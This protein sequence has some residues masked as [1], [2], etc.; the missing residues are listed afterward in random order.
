MNDKN[1]KSAFISIV[2]MANVGKS[3]LLN[4]L[5]G[6]KISIISNKPQ[7]TRNKITGILTKGESQLVFLDSPGYHKRKNKLSDYM[8]KQISSVIL[9]VD[10]CVLVVE[11]TN[12]HISEL[13]KKLINQINKLNVDVILVINKIDLLP[14]KEMIIKV[15]EMYSTEINVKSVVP[16]SVKM[17]DGIN[18][19]L[20]ELYKFAKP[21]P[22]FFSDDMITDQMEREMVSEI[23]R[24]K[25]LLNFGAEIPYGVVVAI[26]KMKERKGANIF[27]IESV[28]YCERNSHKG[29]IIGKDGQALK[30]AASQARIDIE[31]MLESKVNLKCWVK[32]KNNWRN[33]EKIMRNFGYDLR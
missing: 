29:I 2:G 4:K 16:I 23:I 15:I 6:Q 17:N 10:V 11:A 22:H 19:L 13:E 20:D 1:S 33:N 12:K 18:I 5:V 26:E 9:D 8:I 24:E 31:E 32:V 21:S 30:K 3:S 25:M 14:K 27:D 28:I 7:T